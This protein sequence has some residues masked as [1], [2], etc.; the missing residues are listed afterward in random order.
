MATRTAVPPRETSE[1]WRTVLGE[2]FAGLHP[3]P[4]RPG[5]MNGH[6]S[7][8]TLGDLHT[9]RVEG[10][11]QI[12]RRGPQS[13]RSMP[14]EL[15]KVC[16]QVRGR[17]TIHQ[18]D[19]ELVLN[20]GELAVYD[21]GKPYDLR[22]DGSWSCAVM[23]FPRRALGLPMP[24][25]QTLMG[26]VHATSRGPGVIL[27]GFIDTSVHRIDNEAPPVAKVRLGDAGL[28]LLA[29]TLTMASTPSTEDAPA[30]ARLQL[31]EYVRVH[32]QDTDLSHA[33]VAAAHHMS[34]RTLDRL[35]EGEPI[36]VS[37]HIRELRLEGVRHELNDPLSSNQSVSAIAARWCFT[38]SAHLSRL[39][40]ARFGISP[41]AARH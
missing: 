12:V 25:V 10:T 31:L 38:D 40:K 29:S 39:F 9:F 21:T 34:T 3:E 1:K 23:A 28:S 7:A 37:G 18:D 13:V 4:S 33:A 41:S 17:A 6:I 11:P 24:L 26:R 16:L 8:A 2:T 27:A 32:I 22:L 19:K 15:L 30:A 36:T 20:P 5:A 14:T 35:F